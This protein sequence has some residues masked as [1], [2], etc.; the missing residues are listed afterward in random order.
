LT[1]TDTGLTNGQPYFYK[2][3][4]TNAV[5]AGPN[6]SETFATPSHPVSV[7]SAPQGFE[8]TAGNAQITLNWS[9]PANDGG[10]AITGYIVYRGTNDSSL[11]VLTSVTTTTFVDTGLMAGQTYYYE[12][13]ATNQAGE[14]AM[15]TVVSATPPPATTPSTDNTTLLV[16]IG[17]VVVL[18]AIGAGALVMR[19][20]K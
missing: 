7:P 10:G 20:R 9:A 19:R 16:G 13:C 5:G 14:G 12:I 3:S 1:Y 4:A 6:S 15:T 18:A 2:V 8:A 11:S 17:A